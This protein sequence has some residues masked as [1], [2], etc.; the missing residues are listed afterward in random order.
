MITG[1]NITKTFKSGTSELTVLDNVNLE[2]KAGEAI[3]LLGPSGAGKST[4]LQILGTLDKPTNGSVLFEGQDLFSLSDDEIARFRNEKM[5]FVFQFHHLVHE[6]TALENVSLPC[7]L[8]GEDQELAEKQATYWLEFMGLKDRV[9]HYPDQLSGGELQRVSIARALIRNPQILF[10][11]EPTGNLDSDNSQKIQELFF[12][13]QN[14]LGLTLVVVT[15]DNQFARK[16]SKV[17]RVQDG[18]VLTESSLV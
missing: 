9:H 10:A 15:H 1:Q 18:H 8:V 12:Q 2:I 17:Y 6:L 11:D 14:Q 5:G 13:L 7:R 3:C 16:F 4:L